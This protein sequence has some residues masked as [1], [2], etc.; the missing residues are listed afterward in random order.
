[1]RKRKKGEGRKERGPRPQ[2]EHEAR[3]PSGGRTPACSKAEEIAAFRQGQSRFF[4]PPRLYAGA[5]SMLQPDGCNFG[6]C[7]SVVNRTANTK[8]DYSVIEKN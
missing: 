8:R 2:G 6:Q 3:R 1:V 4:L 7:V 5:S